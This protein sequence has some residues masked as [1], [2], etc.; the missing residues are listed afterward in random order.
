M[1]YQKKYM[2][3]CRP[4]FKDVESFGLDEN[5]HLQVVC[6]CG[7]VIYNLDELHSHWLKGHFDVIL[8]R[9]LPEEELGK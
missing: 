9:D 2:G 7:V 8:E 6:C 4:D 1:K 3:M 5:N